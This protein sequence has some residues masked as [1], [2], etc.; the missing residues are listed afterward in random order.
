MFYNVLLISLVFS[1]CSC[2][3]QTQ[4][5]IEKVSYDDLNQQLRWVSSCANDGILYQLEQKKWGKWRPTD[6]L[7]ANYFEVSPTEGNN[8][9]KVSI[10]G[11]TSSSRVFSFIVFP[12]GKPFIKVGDTIFI[13][14]IAPVGV[15]DSYG[16]E[17]YRDTTDKIAVEQFDRGLYYLLVDTVSFDLTLR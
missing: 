7:G 16:N 15:F 2:T 13:D 1:L 14:R 11:D 12:E 6:T 9:Y 5:S 4:C 10:L 8:E 3:D 17:L